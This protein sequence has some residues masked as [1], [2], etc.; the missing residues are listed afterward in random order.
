MEKSFN[1]QKKSKSRNALYEERR[2]AATGQKKLTFWVPQEFEA[3]FMMMAEFCREN[4]DYFPSLA[5][6]VK[7]GK[8]AKAVD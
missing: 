6:S 3:E 1:T 5:R 2:K 4:K 7:T 8:Y